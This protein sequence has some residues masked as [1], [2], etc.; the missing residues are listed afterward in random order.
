MGRIKRNNYMVNSHSIFFLHFNIYF[1]VG[2]SDEVL[3]IASFI[4]VAYGFEWSN[5]YQTF[6]AH[7]F[8]K[9]FNNCFCYLHACLKLRFM[10][11]RTHMRRSDNIV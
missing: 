7:N 6:S 10:V 5:I 1:V 4:G 2:L 11:L 3:C 9:R 8:F